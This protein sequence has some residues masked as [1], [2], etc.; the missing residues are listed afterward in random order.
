M[1]RQRVGRYIASRGRMMFSTE[2]GVQMLSTNNTWN[3]DYAEYSVFCPRL[4]S[5]KQQ[6]KA[7]QKPTNVLD[8]QGIRLSI[9]GIK[10]AP[11]IVVTGC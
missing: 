5:Q 4:E 10:L 6:I 11:R 2:Q 9:Q 1:I 7:H 8:F 3:T